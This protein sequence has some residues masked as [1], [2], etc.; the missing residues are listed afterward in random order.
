[1]PLLLISSRFQFAHSW[2]LPSC[3][4]P[5]FPSQYL[6][7]NQSPKLWASSAWNSYLEFHGGESHWLRRIIV[8][9][10]VPASFLPCSCEGMCASQNSNTVM[11]SLPRR[12]PE[13]GAARPIAQLIRSEGSIL[14]EPDDR[15]ATASAGNWGQGDWS[16][17]TYF[18]SLPLID[19]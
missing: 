11:S 19:C 1:M 10:N 14:P 12:H 18:A 15:R 17:V 8:R 5:L 16:C 3:C 13:D 9:I 6:A 4:N 7:R 2:L